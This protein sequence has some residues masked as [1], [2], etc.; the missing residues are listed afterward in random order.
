MPTLDTT[1]RT[2]SQVR[3]MPQWQRLIDS[4]HKAQEAA[5]YDG[6]HF[7]RAEM[8][9]FGATLIGKPAEHVAYATRKPEDFGAY[10]VERQTLTH[11]D[12]SVTVDYVLKAVYGDALERVETIARESMHQPTPAQDAAMAADFAARAQ[13]VAGRAVQR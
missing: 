4:I 3:R 8:R 10:W 9:A 5:G 6:R 1:R 11:S 12:D 2:L 7:G 13:A